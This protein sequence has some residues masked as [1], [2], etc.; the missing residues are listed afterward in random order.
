[1]NIEVKDGEVKIN[2]EEV[3]NPVL[4]FLVKAFGPVFAFFV[5]SFTG[6]VL[7]FVALCL[8]LPILIVVTVVIL[9]L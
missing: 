5:V 8:L 3:E 2:G 7:L 6:A 9:L 4:R 1:M